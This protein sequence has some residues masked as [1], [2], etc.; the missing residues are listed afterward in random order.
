MTSSD[1][2]SA[3]AFEQLEAAALVH[4]RLGL[5]GL[6]GGAEDD[7]EDSVT[8][9]Q[10]ALA[11]GRRQAAAEGHAAGLS[12]ARAQSEPL[13]SALRDALDGIAALRDEVAEQIERAA[14]ELALALS[15]QIVAG[16][17]EVQPERILDVVRGALRRLA[18]RQRI[19]V[20]VNPDDQSYLAEHFEE[21]C[22]ELG[23]IGEGTVQAD[24]R[25]ARGDALVQTVEGTLDVQVQSQLERARAIVAEE[26]GAA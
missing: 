18:D 3:F 1:P 20:I 23:G 22:S 8:R 14:V 17:I 4:S 13:L 15:E 19:T 16:A 11:E 10:R 21:L 7:D 12:E 2:A 26:L 5:E 24:R 25:V 6:A 9:E